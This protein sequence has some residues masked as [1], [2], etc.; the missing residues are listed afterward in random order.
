MDRLATRNP[1]FYIVRVRFRVSLYETYTVRFFID[2]SRFPGQTLC[3]HCIARNPRDSSSSLWF[4]AATPSR[5][6]RQEDEFE[7]RE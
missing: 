6:R 4:A 7:A 5:E 2:R 3:P 1:P